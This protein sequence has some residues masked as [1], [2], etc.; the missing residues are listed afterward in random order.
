MAIKLIDLH[1]INGILKEAILNNLITIKH[2]I[3]F[4]LFDSILS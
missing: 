3:V 4:N 1:L 2:Q